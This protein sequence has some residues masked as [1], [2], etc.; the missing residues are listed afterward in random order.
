MSSGEEQEQDAESEGMNQAEQGGLEEL[1]Q[2]TALGMLLLLRPAQA[3]C[4]ILQQGPCS[5]CSHSSFYPVTSSWR[6]SLLPREN[7]S[8]KKQT[9][10]ILTKEKA[11][12]ALPSSWAGRQRLLTPLGSQWLCHHGVVTQEPLTGMWDS[13]GGLPSWHCGGQTVPRLAGKMI[14][15]SKHTGG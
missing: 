10:G 14:Q 13:S 5:G 4:C 9:Q 2:S 8:G 12:S 1:W 11:R 3:V 6:F 7:S 15:L